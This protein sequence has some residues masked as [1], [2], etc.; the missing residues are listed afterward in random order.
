MTLK[1]VIRQGD[2]TS[3]G[4]SVLAGDDSFKVLGKGVARINDP[5]SCPKCGGHQTIAEGT[6][7][8]V[9]TNKQKLALA[10]MKTSCGA[11]LIASQ[12]SFQIKTL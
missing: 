5:V 8:A 6:P 12:T 11:T 10:G 7:T 3:H 1:N 2:R 4:G 9:G